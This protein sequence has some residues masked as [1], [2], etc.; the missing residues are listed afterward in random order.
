MYNVSLFFTSSNITWKIFNISLSYRQLYK[1]IF[2]CVLDKSTQYFQLKFLNNI[3]ST[4]QMLFRLEKDQMC[5]FCGYEVED[6]MNLFG[7]CPCVFLSCGKKLRDGL[8]CTDN[9]VWWFGDWKFTST[10]YVCNF[11]GQKKIQK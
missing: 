11:I 10:F 2:Q 7:L 5:K 8:H 6:M 3:L 1:L 4:R 9:R